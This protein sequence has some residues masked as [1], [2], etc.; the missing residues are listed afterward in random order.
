[1]RE[2]FVFQ[3][4]IYTFRIC[5]P[6]YVVFSSCLRREDQFVIAVF[7]FSRGARGHAVVIVMILFRIFRFFGSEESI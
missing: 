4:E 5:I 7:F 3:T 1:M 2:T 6:S